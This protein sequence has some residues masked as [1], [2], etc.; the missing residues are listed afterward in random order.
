MR[1][2]RDDDNQ[3]RGPKC[4]WCLYLEKLHVSRIQQSGKL[5]SSDRH[6]RWSDSEDQRPQL[7]SLLKPRVT[8]ASAAERKGGVPL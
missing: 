8:R 2:K 4:M 7:A 3:W 1:N 6:P 5:L